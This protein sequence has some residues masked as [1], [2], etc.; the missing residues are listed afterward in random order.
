MT[1]KPT[2][3]PGRPTTGFKRT[4]YLLPRPARTGAPIFVVDGN[5][6]KV[7]GI[8]MHCEGVAHARSLAHALVDGLVKIEV[9]S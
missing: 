4:G 8:T 7:S 5:Q 9:Q 6:V 3:R 1:T 2:A